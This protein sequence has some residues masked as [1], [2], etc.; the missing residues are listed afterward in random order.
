MTH[1]FKIYA[2]MISCMAAFGV[3]GLFVVSYL[4]MTIPLAPLVTI[5]FAVLG[6]IIGALIG[7]WLADRAIEKELSGV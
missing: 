6:Q 3:V 2:W 5:G 4:G 7:L 1:L